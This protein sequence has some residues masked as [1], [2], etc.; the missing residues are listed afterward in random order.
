MTDDLAHYGSEPED[1]LEARAAF[2]R[3]A[4]VFG[5]ARKIPCT[6][7]GWDE[8]AA[9]VEREMRRDPSAQ[10]RAAVEDL[11]GRIS[12]AET[13]DG[14]CEIDWMAPADAKK[15]RT[16]IEYHGAWPKAGG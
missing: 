5:V 13:W 14:R 2:R 9:F 4:D 1:T 12:R 8:L 15:V 7:A 10:A 16:V 3:I 6:P 11:A